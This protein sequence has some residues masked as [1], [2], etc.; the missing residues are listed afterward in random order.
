MYLLHG[1]SAMTLSLQ[2]Q[3]SL[4]RAHGPNTLLGSYDMVCG[5]IVLKKPTLKIEKEACTGLYMQDRTFTL[6]PSV[7]RKA[8]FKPL[9]S[10]H[11]STSRQPSG[12][13]GLV[14][15]LEGLWPAPKRVY[16]HDTDSIL[17]NPKTTY[18][19]EDPTF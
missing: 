18:K 10:N 2:D 17:R 5:T 3:M 14:Q 8:A 7:T 13:S 15:G 19:H 12:A 6:G 1:Q 4:K 9:G 16:P 11:E